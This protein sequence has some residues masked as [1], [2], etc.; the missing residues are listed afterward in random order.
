MHEDFDKIL[1]GKA[2]L[3]WNSHHVTP[4]VNN[5]PNN[6]SAGHVTLNYLLSPQIIFM[7]EKRVGTQ[8]LMSVP[9]PWF[10]SIPEDLLSGAFAQDPSRFVLEG[11]AEHDMCAKAKPLARLFY[12]YLGE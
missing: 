6:D 4:A 7:A 1:M 3:V 9:T 10:M 12:I 5:H 11:F 8:L 2:F